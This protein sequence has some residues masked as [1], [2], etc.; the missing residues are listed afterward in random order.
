[1]NAETK[2]IADFLSTEGTYIDVLTIVQ[3]AQN[4]E[5]AAQQIEDYVINQ[6]RGSEALYQSFAQD[7][8]DFRNVDWLE[9]AQAFKSD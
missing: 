6:R 1:M 5:E 8:K 4:D 9:V 7:D 3:A 2:A